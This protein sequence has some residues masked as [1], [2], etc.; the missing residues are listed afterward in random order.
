MTEFEKI[1]NEEYFP[2]EASRES[3]PNPEGKSY[4]DMMKERRDQCFSMIQSACKEIT[5]DEKHLKLFL[6]VLSRFERYSLNNNILIYAQKSDAV[7]LKDHYKVMSEKQVICK[8]A[9]PISI[10]E[11]EKISGTN[12]EWTRYNAVTKYD[13]SDLENEPPVINTVYDPRMKIRALL[14]KSPV[15]IKT[16]PS[17]EYPQNRPEGAYYDV[18][19]HCVVAKADMSYDEIFLSVAE[20]LAHVEI[21]RSMDD[22]YEPGQHALEAK[23]TAYALARRYDVP[24]DT[25][26]LS[27]VTNQYRNLNEEETKDVLAKIHKSVKAINYRMTQKLQ[28]SKEQNREEG[29]AR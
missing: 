20:A 18:Q 15:A 25:I 6:D 14:H 8:G 28:P 12:G 26:K 16:L 9:K 10:L 27:N 4:G 21:K 29:D 5:S 17:W 24:T 22:V 19:N 13:V 2:K 3:S 23:C 7:K 1:L 11:P